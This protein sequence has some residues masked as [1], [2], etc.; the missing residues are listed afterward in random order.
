MD[1]DDELIGKQVFKHFNSLFQANDLWLAYS[2][3]IGSATKTA[4]FSRPFAEGII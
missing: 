3:F 1:G 2:N 4:G